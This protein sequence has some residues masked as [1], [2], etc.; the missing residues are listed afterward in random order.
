ME[1]RRRIA[2]LGVTGFIGGGLPA[3]LARRGWVCT[4]VSRSGGG[5]VDGVETWSTPTDFDPA[6]YDAILNLAGESID[7]RWTA[8]NRRIFR[9]SRV[10]LTD[11]LVHAIHDLP[12]TERPKVL[13]NGS[14]VG[15]YGDRGDRPLDESAAPGRGPLA[16]LCR[17]WEAAAL[18]AETFG[19]RVVVL[20]TGIVLGRGGGAF[21]KLRRVFRLGLGGRLGSGEQWMSWIHL[22]DL[23]RAIV[24]AVESASLS[25]AVNAVAPA[26]ERN[27]DF[28]RKLA[29][30]L[31]RP[32][33]LPVPAGVL[34]LALGGF[35]AALLDSQRAIPAA[36]AA[37]GFEFRH[38]TLESALTDLTG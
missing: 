15:I 11:T 5:N 18:A 21:A 19:L 23:R 2:I 32:A 3:M 37:D 7:R 28:T 29:A 16:D 33:V 27:A 30:A 22:D 4:G 38:P 34:K 17:D 14:A 26:P 20:R 10:G 35:G 24:R 6:G 1:T 36:L 13:V 31:H 9:E 8:A 25:E 12:A